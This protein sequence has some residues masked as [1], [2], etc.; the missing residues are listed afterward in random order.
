MRRA[1]DAFAALS[2]AVAAVA[3]ACA[4]ARAAGITGGATLATLRGD[5]VE[6]DLDIDRSRNGYSA[7]LYFSARAPNFEFRP[8]ILFVQMGTGDETLL[9]A[10]AAGPLGFEFDYIQVPFLF[11][12][13]SATRR[14]P[15]VGIF[16]GPYFAFNLEAEVTSNVG[17]VPVT[18]DIKDLVRDTDVGAIFGLSVDAGYWSLDIRYTHGFER[19]FEDNSLD[20]RNA[21][22]SVMLGMSF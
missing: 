3:F 21:A 4:L 22:L 19:I 5:D 9:P 20:V 14:H 18:A 2:A 10:I 13:T 12:M 16:F 7:G 1:T 17:G 15:G 8:E 6:I 11:K